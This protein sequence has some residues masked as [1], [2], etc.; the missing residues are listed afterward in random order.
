MKIE[1][2]PARREKLADNLYGQ[3]LEQIMLGRLK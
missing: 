2:T 3:L 1:I